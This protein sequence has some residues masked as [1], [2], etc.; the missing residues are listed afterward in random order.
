MNLTQKILIVGGFVGLVGLVLLV[1]FVFIGK[2]TPKPRVRPP[3]ATPKPAT[4]RV[5][6]PT[7]EPI[8]EPTPAP[9][10][11]PMP[12]QPVVMMSRCANADRCNAKMKEEI[13]K[14][15]AFNDSANS[16]PECENCQT[17]WFSTKGISFDGNNWTNV[18]WRRID[19]VAA[20]NQLY[21]KVK[22]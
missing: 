2:D 14:N 6:M 21:E 3:P 16:F 15:W 18:D 9:T 5:S 20:L 4:P 12:V 8:L 11:A 19:R 13:T 1:Y 10:L 7:L 17:R 22:L